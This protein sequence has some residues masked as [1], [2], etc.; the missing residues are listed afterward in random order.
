MALP[1]P[2]RELQ[3]PAHSSPDASLGG[4]SAAWGL[5]P[6]CALDPPQVQRSQHQV[7]RALCP[8]WVILGPAHWGSRGVFLN[9][10][11]YLYV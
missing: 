7:W 8:I 6:D 9:I 5:C 2:A 4:S 3:L 10:H 1:P 11:I